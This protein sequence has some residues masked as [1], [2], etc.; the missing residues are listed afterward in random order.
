[1]GDKDIPVKDG[2]AGLD[3]SIFEVFLFDEAHATDLSLYGDDATDD[4]GI[5]GEWFIGPREGVFPDFVIDIGST[6]DPGMF[7]IAICW[8]GGLDVDTDL[9]GGA[10]EDEI[11]ACVYDRF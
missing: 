6:L 4:E 3:I 9:M 8:G 7:F 2:I 5:I 1:M 10:V 11:G